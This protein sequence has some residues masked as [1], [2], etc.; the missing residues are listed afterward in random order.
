MKGVLWAMMYVKSQ[1]EVIKSFRNVLEHTLESKSKDR[2]RVRITWSGTV[3]CLSYFVG[4]SNCEVGGGERGEDV[5]GEGGRR[6]R[7]GQGVGE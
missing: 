5:V 6:S 3:S 7:L 1:V 2:I 4:T